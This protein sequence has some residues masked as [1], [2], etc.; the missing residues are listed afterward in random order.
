MI[1][2][3]LLWVMF[4]LHINSY[5]GEFFSVNK[6]RVWERIPQYF[7]KNTVINFLNEHRLTNCFDYLE[8]THLLLLKCWRDNTIKNVKIEIEDNYEKRDIMLI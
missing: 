1:K 6:A 4:M 8:N 2:R 5:K 7:V 3:F